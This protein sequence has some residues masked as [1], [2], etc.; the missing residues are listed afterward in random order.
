M[1]LISAEAD[2]GRRKSG[3]YADIVSVAADPTW[4]INALCTIDFVTKGGEVV[5]EDRAPSSMT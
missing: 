2:S 4:V 3:Q 5:R 1:A